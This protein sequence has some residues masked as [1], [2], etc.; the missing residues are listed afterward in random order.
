MQ[1]VQDFLSPLNWE[2]IE[3]ISWSTSPQDDYWALHYE[4]SGVFSVRSAYR[5]VVR[6]RE[7]LA[8]W[9]KGRPYRSNVD[10]QEKEWT[11]LWR[12]KVPSKVQIFLWRFVRHSIP[13][14]D[15]RHDRNMAADA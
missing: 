14:G 1:A 15:V 8:A 5:M 4:K 9:A 13:T 3:S 6:S 12:T 10:S 7:T 2:L 11:K